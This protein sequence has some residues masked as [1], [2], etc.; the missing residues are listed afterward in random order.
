MGGEDIIGEDPGLETA[1]ERKDP[2]PIPLPLPLFP[3]VG[4]HMFSSI[5]LKPNPPMPVPPEAEGGEIAKS[6]EAVDDDRIE[7]EFIAIGSVERRFDEAGE[8]TE[9]RVDEEVDRGKDGEEARVWRAG[10]VVD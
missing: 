9:V 1:P 6:T 8:L 10:V 5:L 2:L 7:K 4:F 3:L